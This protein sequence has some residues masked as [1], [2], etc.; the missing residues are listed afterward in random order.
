MTAV[1][2]FAVSCGGGDEIKLDDQNGFHQ[3]VKMGGEHGAMVRDAENYDE[4]KQGRATIE[5]Y[6]DAFKTQLGGESYL[7]YLKCAISAIDGKTLS[8]SNINSDEDILY[9]RRFY[10]TLNEG[11]GVDNS[12][13]EIEKRGVEYG[14][15]LKSAQN[16][17][18]YTALWSEVMAIEA[19]LRKAGNVDAYESFVYNVMAYL[20]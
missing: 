15:K 4:F 1:T 13:Q 2:L 14:Q 16:Y 19:E 7:A 8:E 6:R 20:N 11:D 10:N 18:E 5:K 17:E 12:L 9:I 3:A